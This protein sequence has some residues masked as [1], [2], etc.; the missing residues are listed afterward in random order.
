[1]NR[2]TCHRNPLTRPAPMLLACLALSCAATAFAADP[3]VRSET[4]K[5]TDLDVDTAAGVQTLYNRIHVAS[6]HVCQFE[7]SKHLEDQIALDVCAARTEAQAV[8]NINLPALTA[9]YQVKMGNQVPP[10]VAVR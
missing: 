9:Y 5:F 10:R 2:R 1:M 4:I 7:A 8:R 6:R 3:V